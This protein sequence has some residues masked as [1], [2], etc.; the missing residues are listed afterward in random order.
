MFAGYFTQR[1]MIITHQFDKNESLV[2]EIRNY[3]SNTTQDRQSGGLLS[4]F[5]MS[6][7]DVKKLTSL[8]SS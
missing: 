6:L 1:G 3:M 7:H 4:L 8:G 5:V 2:S